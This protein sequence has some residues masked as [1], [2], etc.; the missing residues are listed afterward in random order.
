MKLHNYRFF[1]LLNRTSKYNAFAWVWDILNQSDKVKWALDDI[2]G[3]NWTA[4]AQLFLYV[5]D[6]QSLWIWVEYLPLQ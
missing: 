3:G 5:T 1:V 6:N 2:I 4:Y